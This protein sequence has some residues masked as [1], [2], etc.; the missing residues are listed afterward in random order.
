MR[1]GT[2]LAEEVY[3]LI[4]GWFPVAHIPPHLELLLLR[5]QLLR[6]LS[7]NQFSE[8]RVVAVY[9][10]Q[11]CPVH[12]CSARL[13]WGSSRG[14]LIEHIEMAHEAVQQG[15]PVSKLAYR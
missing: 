15:Q 9:V 6:D 3:R 4:D 7:G 5:F 8:L 14:T 10:E 11:D 1:H 2:M 12:A 13:G